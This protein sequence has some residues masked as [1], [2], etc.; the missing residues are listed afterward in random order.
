MGRPRPGQGAVS[1]VGTQAWLAS[2][3]LRAQ[4][5]YMLGL[6]RTSSVD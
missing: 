4:S 5:K 2:F 6:P 3:M 1:R